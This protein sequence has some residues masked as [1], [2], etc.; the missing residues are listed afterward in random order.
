MAE[1]TVNHRIPAAAEITELAAMAIGKGYRLH[2][3]IPLTDTNPHWWQI[4]EG[5]SMKYFPAFDELAGYVRTL[6]PWKAR[7][8]PK[9][10]TL[11]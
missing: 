1:V 11:P 10:M 4:Q 6:E 8:S 7:K 9:F 3:C 2:H 5:S